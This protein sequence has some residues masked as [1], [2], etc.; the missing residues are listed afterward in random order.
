[1]KPT[2]ADVA[3]QF[4]RMSQAYLESPGH[5]RGDDLVT[6][7][8]FLE[9]TPAM[10][11]LDVAT[12]AGHTAVAVAP[13]V[14]E[15]VAIDIAPAMLRRT[16]ELAEAR[17]VTNVSTELMDVEAMRFPD[18]CFDAAT[19]RIAP[20]H[21]ID[22]DQAL[23]EIA[24]VLRP[25]GPFVVEDS[26][27]P[28]DSDLDQ[29]LN[30]LERIRDATHVR[31]LTAQQWNLKLVSAGMFPKRVSKYRKAH[32]VAQWIA[33]SGLDSVGAGRVYEAFDR[34]SDAAIEC[35][36]IVFTGGRAVSFT[37]DKIII[38]AEKNEGM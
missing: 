9:P 18:A 26:A 24:R 13:R 34:A 27:V 7:L 5:A 33:R 32:D 28:E 31:S 20:H 17:G 4:D 19:C 14:R 29:F 15:V 12:G 35:F 30:D 36:A 22:I 38:R 37:D 16:Q 10:S 23:R 25:G 21:F 2:K 11:V 6:V 1:M 8:R 3:R